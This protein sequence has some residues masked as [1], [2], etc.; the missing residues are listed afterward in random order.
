MPTPPIP[1]AL[2][3]ATMVEL[4]DDMGTALTWIEEGHLDCK[5][6]RPPRRTTCL[7]VFGIA[8]L[9]R[10]SRCPGVCM[11]HLVGQLASQRLQLRTRLR[12][13]TALRL[14]FQIR[15]IGLACLVG[16][17]GFCICIAKIEISRRARWI[18]L[19]GVLQPA[20]SF[21]EALLAYTHSPG[22]WLPARNPGA[23][24][25]HRQIAQPHRRSAFPCTTA[26][27][28]R[29]PI[30]RVGGRCSSLRWVTP[31]WLRHLAGFLP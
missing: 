2:A 26:G 18:D 17:A 30:V 9:F 25:A 1:A 28:V 5:R 13:A 14:Q 4:E 19:Q 29:W 7:P 11:Q 8:Y 20:R 16:I 21:G 15:R 31:A 27:R 22:Y 12:R 6:R 24:S 10:Q 23:A 3:M